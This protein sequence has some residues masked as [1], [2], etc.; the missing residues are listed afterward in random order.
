MR[1]TIA[2]WSEVAGS[3]DLD[4]GKAALRQTTQRLRPRSFWADI[5]NVGKDALEAAQGNA[6]LSQS[7][8]FAV[9][10]G[11]PSQKTSIYSDNERRFSIDCID[12]Y[13]TGSWGI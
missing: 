1:T 8:S 10:M 11:Q 5:V 13:I 9:N 3:Y 6:D 2:A 4:F 12:C 7:V